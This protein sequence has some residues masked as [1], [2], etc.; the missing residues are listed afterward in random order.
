MTLTM[1]PGPPGHIG[2]GPPGHIATGCTGPPGHT[3]HM[4]PTDHCRSRS[5]AL[6]CCRTTVAARSPV[7][8]AVDAAVVDIE[9]LWHT[10]PTNSNLT[11]FLLGILLTD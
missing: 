11:V 1:I 8:P 7:L 5:H 10:E 9:Q 2:P 4:D 6:D 3:C